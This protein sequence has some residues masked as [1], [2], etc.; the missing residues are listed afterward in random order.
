MASGSARIAT[1][2]WGYLD[3][4][5]NIWESSYSIENN[6]SVVSANVQL[7][8]G[9]SSGYFSTSYSNWGLTGS[10]GGNAGSIK[11]SPE[12]WYTLG[13]SSWTV[14]HNND[15]T[16]SA[17]ASGSASVYQGS[18]SASA[19]I[20]LTTIP[21]KSNPSVSGNVNAGSNVVIYTNR[22]ANS[23]THILDYNIN[24]NTGRIA[25][26]V[27]ANYTW[28]VPQSVEKYFTTSGS[29][30]CT[31]TCYTYSGSTHIGTAT[32]SFTI[33]ASSVPNLSN[34]SV[35]E[36]NDYVL[37]KG[38]NITV[39]KIS[40][41]YI[42]VTATANNG[43]SIKSV[44]CNGTGLSHMGS[45][46]YAGTL[47]NLSTG[48]FRITATDYRGKVSYSETIQTTYHQ[49]SVPVINATLTR[50]GDET[51]SDAAYNV[52]CTFANILNNTITKAIIVRENGDGDP[53]TTTEIK[54]G[55]SSGKATYS[56]TYDN[57]FYTASYYL[58]LSVTDSFGQTISLRKVLPMGQYSFAM[59]KY[60]VVLHKDSFIF[61]TTDNL[62]TLLDFNHPVGSI[63]ISTSANDTPTR[64][65]GTWTNTTGTVGSIS[66]CY[67]WTRTA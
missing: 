38:S 55:I 56:Y 61:E 5:V 49:Y 4:V 57:M 22:K 42:A 15:G 36:K 39:Q 16:G 12:G 41:K 62:M 17:S 8:H 10:G 37:A 2:S 1:R 34:F 21:R 27:G 51:S 67:I 29:A 23:F 59:L 9:G 66:N 40:K 11:T 60:G 47:I 53:S 65:G 45:N 30:T 48:D 52:D 3:V 24:G 50:V 44:T 33:Y 32:T 35:T 63:Y 13:S 18:A 19:S 54:M 6:T 28:T 14:T 26:G 46:V 58:T 31:V 20:T 7:H 64:F 43:A 25:S